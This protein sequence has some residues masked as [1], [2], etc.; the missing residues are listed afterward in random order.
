MVRD[1]P[2]KDSSDTSQHKSGMQ[3]ELQ[4]RTELTS[5]S[6]PQSLSNEQ[7]GVGSSQPSPPPPVPQYSIAKTRR[8]DKLFLQKG[9][10]R[11]IWLL[12]L[13]M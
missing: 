12:I 11:L 13:S 4:T 5:V 3:V 7:D 6:T 2:T 8:E 1:F 10:S 9:M